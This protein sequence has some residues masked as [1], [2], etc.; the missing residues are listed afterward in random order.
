MSNAKRGTQSKLDR[1]LER[2]GERIGEVLAEL[3]WQERTALTCWR[4]GIL[5]D[6]Y[7]VDHEAITEEPYVSIRRVDRWTEEYDVD[8]RR[9]AEK[10]ANE[11]NPQRDERIRKQLDA[12]LKMRD[13]DGL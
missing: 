13:E 5:P 12:F 4:D 2:L 10:K 9:A 7:E 11:D 6:T 8:E 1:S 3:S